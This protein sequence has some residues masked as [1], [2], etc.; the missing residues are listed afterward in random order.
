MTNSSDMLSDSGKERHTSAINLA[1]TSAAQLFLLAAG[2]ALEYWSGLFQGQSGSSLPVVSSQFIVLQTI[3]TAAA[4]VLI[5]RGLVTLF[6]QER[7]TREEFSLRVLLAVVA[8]SV[9]V[10]LSLFSGVLPWLLGDAITAIASGSEPLRGQPRLTDRILLL[11]LYALLIRLFS[12]R[13]RTWRGLK[14]LQH[15]QADQRREHIGLWSEGFNEAKRILS[16][17]PP[18]LIYLDRTDRSEILLLDSTVS[19][20]AWKDQAK[21]LLRLS[22]SS[23]AFDSDTGWHDRHNCWMGRN[24]N[25]NGLVFL[26]PARSDVTTDQLSSFLEY[27]QRMAEKEGRSTEEV[28]IASQQRLEVTFPSSGSLPVRC[29]TEREF[30]DCLVDFRDYSNEIR[31]RVLMS[32]LPESDLV[33]DHVYVPSRLQN[34][35]GKELSRSIE[36]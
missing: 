25:T 27:S 8:V 12:T 21:E 5:A 16:G 32:T 24:I 14:T 17:K 33:I 10:I 26:L 1:T 11:L 36:E 30:L 31:R 35:E 23:Y 9:A 28:V 3:A 19:S 13:H 29:V 15:H 18:S 20:L 2:L 34:Q 22:S 7:F 4:L 6:R